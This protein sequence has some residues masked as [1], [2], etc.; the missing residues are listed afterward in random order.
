MAQGGRKNAVPQRYSSEV[1]GSSF[2][3]EPFTGI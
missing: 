2:L 1:D 3:G